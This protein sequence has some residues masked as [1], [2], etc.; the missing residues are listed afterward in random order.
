MPRPAT[1]KTRKT[2]TSDA[3]ARALAEGYR[4]G[5]EEKLAAQLQQAGVKAEYEPVTIRYVK[6]EKEH[7]YT[8]DYVLPNGIIIESKGRFVTADRQK[9]LHIK[10]NHPGLDIRFVFSNPRNRIGKKS[11]TT[12][13]MWCDKHGFKWSGP[14]IPTEWLNEPRRPS[15]LDALERITGWTPS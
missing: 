4:S 10:E 9:H 11:Q 13:A 7:R 1:A 2:R 3:R 14:V 5:L 15:R 12:Y 6:P 8:P